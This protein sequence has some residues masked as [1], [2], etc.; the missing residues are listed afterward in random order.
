MATPL[1]SFIRECTSNIGDAKKDVL[2][3]ICRQVDARDDLWTPF[4]RYLELDGVFIDQ[5]HLFA[6]GGGS[7]SK[8]FMLSLTN[9]HPEMTISHFRDICWAHSRDVI[10]NMLEGED[11]DCFM[12]DIR[13]NI[14]SRICILLEEPTFNPGWKKV[15]ESCKY[16]KEEIEEIEKSILHYNCFSPTTHILH[17]YKE[18]YPK[19]KFDKIL[20]FLENNL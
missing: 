14:W 12:L 10:Y 18:L 13:Y 17:R 20:H 4:A 8:Q 19:H 1:I 7:P 9:T 5:I 3:R 16:T 6:K 2:H 15:G 11:Q